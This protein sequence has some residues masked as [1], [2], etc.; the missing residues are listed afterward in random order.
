MHSDRGRYTA[1]GTV[2][3][4]SSGTADFT[5]CDRGS[6]FGRTG[7]FADDVTESE[8]EDVHRDNGGPYGS[9]GQDRNDDAGSGTHYGKDSGTNGHTFETAEKPHG[10]KRRKD[11]QRRDQQRPHQVHRQYD[12]D[13][14]DHSDQQI[15][16]VGRGSGGLGESLIEGHSKDLVVK[17]DKDRHDKQGKD[18]AEEHF[19][20]RQCQ[21]GSGSEKRAAHI[22][23]QVRAC[24]KNIH[25]QVADRHRPDRD[26]GNGRVSLDLR[27]LARMEKQ[28]SADHG[29]RQH[30]Q[31]LIGK[32]QHRGNGHSSESDMRKPVP[33]K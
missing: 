9:S 23:G 25:D 18:R 7:G 31:H 24:G 32:V 26:H 2:K 12:D 19:P 6:F 29:H 22:T 3:R 14:D 27:I 13:G 30:Q 20:F 17:Q 15:I 4:G 5:K 8:G 11:H 16:A 21:D 1:D 28:H 33:D 10:R